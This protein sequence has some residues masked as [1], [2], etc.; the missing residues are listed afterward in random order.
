MSKFKIMLC[1]DEDVNNHK[2]HKNND[3]RSKFKPDAQ[4]LLQGKVQEPNGTSDLR[5]STAT[6]KS[7]IVT[8][9]DV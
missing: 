4:V 1:R 3:D 8:R 5:Y 7:E 2:D 6:F 9:P